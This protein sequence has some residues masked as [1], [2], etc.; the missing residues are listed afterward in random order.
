MALHETS[1]R[2]KIIH[3]FGFEMH[4][5]IFFLSAILVLLFSS[6][7]LAFPDTA[8]A[9]LQGAKAWSLRNFDWLYATTPIISLLFCVGIAISP[10][11]KI[12][13]GG[14]EAKAEYSV[15]S[16]IAML[17]A[18]GVGIGFMF[19]GTAEPL[20]Y[21]TDWFGV[22]FDTPAGSEDARRLA[23]ST[24]VFHWGILAWSVYAII[25]VSLAFF[26]FNL[27][28]PL[29][30]RSAFYPFL[31]E[32][33]YGWVGDVIDLLA[34]VSTIFGLACT[35][36]IGAT[37]AT[38][39]LAYLFGVE[40]SVWLQI[41]LIGV[42]TAV[43]ILSVLRGLNGGIKVLSN[44]NMIA[45]ASLLLF[46]MIFG[47]TLDIFRTIG[48]SVVSLVPDSLALANWMDRPDQAFLYDWTLFYWAWWIAWSPFV[49]MFIARISK[50]R[51]I[52][53][54]MAG[55]LLAPLVIGIVWFCAFGET[56]IKQFENQTGDLANGVSDAS[57]TLFQM[58]GAMPMPMVTSI[59]ALGLLIIFIVT[60]AD[61]GALVVDK[62]TSGGRKTTPKRQRVFWAAMLGL[63]AIALLYGGGTAALQ[64][65]QAGTITAAL[66][67][68][69]IVL[70]TCFALLKGLIDYR[71]SGRP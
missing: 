64:S 45:A 16:W 54:F 3:A 19:Y 27:G 57:L 22:P 47:P 62:L 29:S 5:P 42:M 71:R 44:I 15:W 21:F 53:E 60:S 35:I 25:G 48:Q 49:G 8:N 31:G 63:T 17:F 55:L 1:H 59:I 18:A 68:A 4:N 66:P 43:A 2:S 32:R 40:Q 9:A 13:L 50:G 51:T 70:L 20:G 58:L 36:G 34:V 46:V 24:S 30:I 65:L 41:I 26:A 12:R 28:L 23:F 33:I 14:A 7:T 52:R 69:V 11:G 37:Q 38:G 56:A 10:L 61:S 6:A 67:F 39:G